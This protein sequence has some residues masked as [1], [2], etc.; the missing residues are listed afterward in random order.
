MRHLSRLMS[1]FFV[2]DGFSGL[3][4]DS[5]TWRISEDATSEADH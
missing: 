1:G 3:L 5:T 4:R 2:R